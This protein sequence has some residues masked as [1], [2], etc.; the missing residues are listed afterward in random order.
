MTDESRMMSWRALITVN[1]A[2]HIFKKQQLKKPLPPKVPDHS[3]WPFLL[4]D[5]T[6]TTAA[7]RQ[8]EDW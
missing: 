6:A 3:A 4:L 2:G 8:T 7:S 5:A 1:R